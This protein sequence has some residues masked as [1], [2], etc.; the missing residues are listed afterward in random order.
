MNRVAAA[1]GSRRVGRYGWKADIAT[2]DEMVGQAF[3]NEM[4]MHDVA[5]VAPVTAFL[6]DLS[7]PTESAR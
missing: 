4:G 3:A 1:D 6:R 5:A 2:L 7:R